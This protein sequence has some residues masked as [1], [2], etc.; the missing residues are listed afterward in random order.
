MAMSIDD[1]IKALSR[2]CE[3]ILNEDELRRKLARSAE[4]H[5]PLRIKLGMDPTAPDVTLGHAVPLSVIRQ[6]QDW[7][8]KA[9]LIIGDYTARVGDPS[10]RNELRPSLD[11][12]RIDTNAKTYVSQVGK[13]LLTDPDHLEVRYNGEWLGAMSMM[14]VIKLLSRKT[15][16]QLLQR[17][18]FAN[19]FEGKVDIYL[20]E[21][22]YPL[23]QG[24]DSVIIDAD[25]EMGGSDQLFNN[26]VGREF[27]KELG[28]E[29]QVVIVTPLLVGTDGAIK[30]SKSKGNYIGITDPPAG[31]AG[32]FGKVMSL[33][34]HVME[35]YYTLLTDLPA[36]QFKPLIQSNPRDA[37]VALA[38]YLI[39]WLHTKEAADAAAEEFVRTTHGGIPDEMP[40]IKVSGPSKL[41]PLMVKAGMVSSNSEG[42]R[43]IK[44]KAVR[45]DG[46]KVTDPQQEFTFDKPVVMQ[47]GNRKFV[48]LIP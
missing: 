45:L 35:M 36:E 47:L 24:W 28:K 37:K 31:A 26:L 17:E 48:R 32:M 6:F 19:R 40:E 44:E 11:P 5:R 46:E 25:V 3:R 33:P 21:L 2:R 42:I 29:P 7:G 13:I 39:N 22:I 14:E 38:K 20:H 43:K 23:M 30:M 8:H 15:V 10:G 34:D 9:V 12:A 16:A 4:T 27:Q 41:A 18:D 1:Q